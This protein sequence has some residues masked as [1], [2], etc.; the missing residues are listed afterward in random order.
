L[1]VA[2]LTLLETQRTIH[3]AA[4][5]RDGTD[6]LIR[7]VAKGKEGLEHLNILRTLAASAVPENHALPLL[8]ELEKD[9]MVFA[10]FP[11]VAANDDVPWFSTISELL[12]LVHQVLRVGVSLTSPS[13]ASAD[14]WLC[15][16]S[17]FCTSP[18]SPIVLVFRW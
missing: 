15:R 6:V 2:S 10:V 16:P 4:R 1:T 11:L 9:D 18:S 8:A 17:P 12:E 13:H 5:A 3:T 14:G 7:L